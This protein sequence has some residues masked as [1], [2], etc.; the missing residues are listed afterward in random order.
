MFKKKLESE[1]KNMEKRENLDLI[2]LKVYKYSFLMSHFD[3]Q[4][5][6]FIKVT[7]GHRSSIK[8]EEVPCVD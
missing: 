8:V 2:H 3:H 7:K 5:G 1:T 4:N 6:I